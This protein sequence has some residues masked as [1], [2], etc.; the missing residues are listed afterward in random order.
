MQDQE[1]LLCQIHLKPFGI[2][3]G[4]C[5]PK[6]IIKK[7]FIVVKCKI[8]DKGIARYGLIYRE[9][10]G[11]CSLNSKRESLKGLLC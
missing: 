10:K 4:S 1:L 11:N 3:L 5:R 9:H 6:G 8:E 2:P 7:Q